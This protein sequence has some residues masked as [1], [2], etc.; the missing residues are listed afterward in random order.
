MEILL[1]ADALMVAALA[2]HPQIGLVV[3]RRG[4]QLARRT[5]VPKTFGR[6][7][8]VLRGGVDTPFYAFEPAHPISID[9]EQ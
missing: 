4:H 5:L 6:L 3:G 2:A 9:N 7:L 8:L 1:R